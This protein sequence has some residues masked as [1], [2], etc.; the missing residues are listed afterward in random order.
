M[1]FCYDF[2]LDHANNK[3]AISTFNR[4]IKR[5]EDCTRDMYHKPKLFELEGSDSR[6]LV[7]GLASKPFIDT[8]ITRRSEA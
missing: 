5:P 3:A 8:R 6:A 4:T 7:D 2:S 1:P